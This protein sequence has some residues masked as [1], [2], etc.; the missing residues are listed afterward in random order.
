MEDIEDIDIQGLLNLI[1]SVRYKLS[2]LKLI[3]KQYVI[4][5]F[6]RDWG[7]KYV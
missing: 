4:Y 2:S 7:Y 1:N 3:A 5:V 6:Y